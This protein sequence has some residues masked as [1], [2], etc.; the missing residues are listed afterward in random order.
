MFTS[1][2]GTV[3]EKHYK[4]QNNEARDGKDHTKTNTLST[5]FR[6]HPHLHIRFLLTA[7][8]QVHLKTQGLQSIAESLQVS[9]SK[10]SQWSSHNSG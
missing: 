8:K 10:I 3:N 7:M 5:S 9:H 4:V 2:P 1:A 6:G